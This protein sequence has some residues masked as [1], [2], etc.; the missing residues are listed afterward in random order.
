MDYVLDG[1]FE[2]LSPKAQSMFTVVEH[3]KAYKTD[4]RRLKNQFFPH[5]KT[6]AKHAHLSR[7]YSVYALKEL[8]LWGIIIREHRHGH[9][10]LYTYIPANDNSKLQ[11]RT[12]SIPDHQAVMLP[13]RQAVMLPDHITTGFE[14]IERTTTANIDLKVY[15]KLVNIHGKNVVDAVVEN[16]VKRNGKVANPTGLLIDAM[17]KGYDLSTPEQIQKEK[18]KARSKQIA[19]ETKAYLIEQD[20][21]RKESDNSDRTFANNTIADFF[22]EHKEL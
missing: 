4:K 13:D 5:I 8:E 20:R 2:R 7:T 21:L 12:V 18:A 10:T 9:S 1:I 3:V 6:L 14:Q 17:K 11:D 19:L 15:N 22:A 16:I